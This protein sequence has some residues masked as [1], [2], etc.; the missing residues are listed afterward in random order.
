MNRTFL[1]RFAA[2]VV[3]FTVTASTPAFADD[4]PPETAAVATAAGGWSTSAGLSPTLMA[5]KG[6]GFEVDVKG[7]RHLRL[8]ASA[9]TLALPELFQNDNAG[10]GWTIRDTGGAAG[11]QVYLRADSRGFY[12]AALVE[13]QNH[14]LER[15]GQSLDALEIGV[16]A[17]LGYRFMPWKG[18]YI[19]PRILA[20]IP[21]Y[22]SKERTLAGE[23]FDDP[24]VRPVPLLYVGWEL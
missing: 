6:I 13:S 24:P 4:G 19:T 21:L 14:H 10:E 11:A 15:A 3:T 12:V 16:A 22:M 18:L 20:V 7:P 1:G 9:Y 8:N 2:L 5:L 23:T 17:E